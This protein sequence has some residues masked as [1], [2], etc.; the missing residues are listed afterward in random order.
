M[1][2]TA[3]IA[4]RDQMQSRTGELVC[5]WG[6]DFGASFAAPTEAARANMLPM[7]GTTTGDQARW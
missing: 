6:L 4:A 5:R 1:P 3:G 7:N 2:S